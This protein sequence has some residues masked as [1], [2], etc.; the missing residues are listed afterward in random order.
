MEVIKSQLFQILKDDV[1]KLLHSIGKLD[2][3]NLAV[4]TRL[5]KVSFHSDSKEGKCQRMFKQWH[6]STYFT[7]QAR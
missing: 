6:S 3:E 7:M 4:A 5:E 2:L 1:V